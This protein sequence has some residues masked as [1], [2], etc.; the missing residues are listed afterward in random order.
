MK[1]L[2]VS[3]LLA[4]GAFAGSMGSAQAAFVTSGTFNVNVTLTSVCTVSTPTAVAFAYT[5]F[6]GTQSNSTGG[7]FSV[8]CTN[9][10]TPALSYTGTPSGGTLTAAGGTFTA[11]GLAYTLGIGTTAGAAVG[12]A[13]AVAV[14]AGNG[15]AQ[16]Y[17]I[18]G[19]MASGQ[20]GT[21]SG[22]TCNDSITGTTLTL[23]Y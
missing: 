9:G 7:Q 17:Y 13:G 11:T 21:C 19:S 8:Q 18:N 16:T 15:T 3:A 22:T 1:K 14:S 10:L 12:T 23:T 5:S 6:Q 2:M 4:A 20:V